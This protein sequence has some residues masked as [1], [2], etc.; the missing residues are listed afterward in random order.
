M[1]RASE[2]TA[3]VVGLSVVTTDVSASVVV[4]ST[5]VGGCVLPTVVGASVD[6]SAIVDE[7]SLDETDGTVPIVDFVSGPKLKVAAS[8]VVSAPIVG[9][10]VLTTGVEAS[11]DVS[12]EIDV[13]TTIEDCASVVSRVSVLMTLVVDSA[14]V[15]ASVLKNVV[16]AS[17]VVSAPIVGVCVLTTGVEDSV[18]ES[19]VLG[20]ASVAEIDV[21]TLVEDFASVVS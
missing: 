18:D 17:V 3:I 4:C 12:A 14:E 21:T 15:S 9:V 8:E 5:N 13:T 20:K 7:A 2:V 11:V 1:G 16:A 10:C 19:A 6:L